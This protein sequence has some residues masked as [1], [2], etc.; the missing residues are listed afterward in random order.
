MDIGWKEVRVLGINTLKT[1]IK[2]HQGQ[3]S[4]VQVIQ[5]V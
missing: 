2:S 5:G 3:D 4:A 1:I